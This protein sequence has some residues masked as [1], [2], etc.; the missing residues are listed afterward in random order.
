MLRW[1][2]VWNTERS[3][4]SS[5]GQW[6]HGKWEMRTIKNDFGEMG[7]DDISENLER[8]IAQRMRL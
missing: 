6:S 7:R 8:E 3:S 1:I 2:T 5:L 4:K